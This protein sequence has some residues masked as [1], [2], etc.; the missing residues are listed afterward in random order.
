MIRRIQNKDPEALNILRGLTVGGKQVANVEYYNPTKDVT[1]KDHWYSGEKTEVVP[2]ENAPTTIRI[3]PYSDGI[4]PATP[5]DVEVSDKTGGGFLGLNQYI[6]SL[7]GQKNITTEDFSD[8]NPN[9]KNAKVEGSEQLKPKQETTTEKLKSGSVLP[10]QIASTD[11]LI[12]GATYTKDGKTYT[13]NGK[14]L[15]PK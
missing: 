1:T 12:T 2:A 3:T 8:K 7:D 4:L 10:E 11:V 9:V 15:I 5:I 13:W 14:K 6:N